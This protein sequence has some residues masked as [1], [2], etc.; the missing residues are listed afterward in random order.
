MEATQKKAILMLLETIHSAV[1][2]AGPMGIPS[3]HLYAMLMGFGF[4]LQTYESFID[5]L[6][7]SGKIKNSNHLLTAV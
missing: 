3:G 5:A 6:V 4:D 7:Q 2:E 1:K